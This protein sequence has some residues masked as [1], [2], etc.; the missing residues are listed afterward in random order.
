MV[1]N[2]PDCADLHSGVA[3]IVCDEDPIHLLYSSISQDMGKVKT[4]PIGARAEIIQDLK[5][6][7]TCASSRQP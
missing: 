3:P 5:L 4:F 6:L 7:Y 1:D 2:I